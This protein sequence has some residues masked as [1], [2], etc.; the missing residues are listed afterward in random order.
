MDLIPKRLRRV[1]RRVR[2]RAILFLWR[3]RR[4][5]GGGLQVD[6]CQKA[7]LLQLVHHRRPWPREGRRFRVLRR[8]RSGRRRR[9]S[10][11]PD[12]RRRRRQPLPR[13]SP[14]R[15][16]RRPL[17]CCLL[18]FRGRSGLLLCALLP[19]GL[20]VSRCS[21]SL[22]RSKLRPCRLLAVSRGR[23][24]LLLCALLPWGLPVSPSRLSLL[25]S[26]LLLFRLVRSTEMGQHKQ[27]KLDVSKQPWKKSLCGSLHCGDFLR[28]QESPA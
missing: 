10:R 11:R 24:G 6:V 23:S 27:V 9:S 18:V 3:E 22:L 20:P 16:G 8:R 1:E 19:C 12:A 4:R 2:G 17:L 26:R 25:R 13:A 15:G 7:A 28:F 5:R 21:S 14:G